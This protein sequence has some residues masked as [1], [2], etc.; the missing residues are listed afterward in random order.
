MV[1]K[2]SLQIVQLF[3]AAFNYRATALR[4]QLQ[5]LLVMFYWS[6]PMVMDIEACIYRD[7]HIE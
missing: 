2:Q 1:I 4:V 3:Q 7:V 6:M 5:R